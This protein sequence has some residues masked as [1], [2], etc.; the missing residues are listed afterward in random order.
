MAENKCISR[1]CL[2]GFDENII[3]VVDDEENKEIQKTGESNEN[4]E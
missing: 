1:I 4:K 3:K 2:I